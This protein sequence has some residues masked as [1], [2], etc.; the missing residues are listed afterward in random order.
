MSA[1]REKQAGANTAGQSEL[2][3]PLGATCGECGSDMELVRP[4]KWQCPK[5][6]LDAMLKDAKRE[7]LLMAHTIA[8]M[9]IGHKTDSPISD[10]CA[11]IEEAILSL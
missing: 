11:E 5:C 6:E 8:V 4:S 3:E 10:I 7:G 1:D 9:Q 2:I